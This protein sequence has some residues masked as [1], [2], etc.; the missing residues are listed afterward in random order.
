LVVDEDAATE[1]MSAATAWIAAGRAYSKTVA[2]LALGAE[3]ERQATIFTVLCQTVNQ[4]LDT[5]K[6]GTLMAGDVF[7]ETHGKKAME[8]VVAQLA[9]EMS[10]SFPDDL[11]QRFNEL[12]NE[13]IDGLLEKV[14]G[15]VS[16]MLSADGSHVTFKMSEKTPLS[17]DP[18]IIKGSLDDLLKEIGDNPSSHYN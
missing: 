10:L 6:E 9:F 16:S 4:T 11:E 13:I 15:A 14:V 12:A 2:Q 8:E 1:M 7:V 3:D 17:N 5:M 18:E